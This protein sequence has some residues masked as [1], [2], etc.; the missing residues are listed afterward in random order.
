MKKS[1]LDR[2]A[3]IIDRIVAR[4]GDFCGIVV[5]VMA[6]LIF[7]EVFMRYVIGRPPLLADEIS[8]YMLVAMT[9]LGMSYVW[10]E[11]GHVRVEALAQRL[12]RENANRLRFV[13]LAIALV[14]AIALFVG[15]IDFIA[16]SVSQNRTSDS[17]MHVPLVWPESTILVGFVLLAAQV[18]TSI[19]R[20]FGI[21][22]SG[23]ALEEEATR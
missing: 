11:R 6:L 17:W 22:K 16:R 10:K 14:F 13:T 4:I 3:N 18:W 12:S 21:V 8:R 9:F 15:S 23:G 2:L 1:L 20:A 7:V 19:W 5:L